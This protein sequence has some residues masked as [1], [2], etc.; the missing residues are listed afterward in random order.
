MK[1]I[2]TIIFAGALFTACTTTTI[3]SPDGTVTRTTSQDP[4]IIKAIAS[5]IA[6]GVAIGV[7]QE[8]KT[9]GLAK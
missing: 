6:Q 4:N 3:T 1:L 7:G 5:G 8:L 2:L 9:Q